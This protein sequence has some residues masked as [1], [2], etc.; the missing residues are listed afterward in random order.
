MV[1]LD[2]HC[3]VNVNWLPPL[4]ARLSDGVVPSDRYSTRAVTPI[5]DVINP[6]TFDYTS[7][8]LVRGGFNWGLHFKWDA[9][10]KGTLTG[11]TQNGYI[12]VQ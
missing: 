2:S 7:S 8:P 5:I 11:N 10:P 1:F 3:E 6:D 9:L 4:L 12:Y